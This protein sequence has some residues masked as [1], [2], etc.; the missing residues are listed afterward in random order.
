MR[1][2]TYIVVNVLSLGIYSFCRFEV[3]ASFAFSDK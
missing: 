2:P 3:K 1:I